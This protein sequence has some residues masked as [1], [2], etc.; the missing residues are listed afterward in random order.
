MRRGHRWTTVA[1]LA[2]VTLVPI[3]FVGAGPASATGDPSLDHL[4]VGDPVPGWTPLPSTTLQLLVTYE[5]KVLG[6]LTNQPVTAAVQ[7]WKDPSGPGTLLVAVIRFPE[8]VPL[9]DRNAREGAISACATG[10]ATAP[11]SV[12]P[13][14]SVPHS[15]E[16]QCSGT[17]ATGAALALTSI[18]WVNGDLFVLVDG[19]GPSLP[20]DRVESYATRQNAS[21]SGGS[22]IVPAGSSTTAIVASLVGALAVAGAVAAVLLVRA[23]RARPAAT[24]AAAS[25][26]AAPTP[27]S[28]PP[29]WYPWAGNPWDLG[30]WD[31]GRWTARKRWDGA[32]WADWA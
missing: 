20:R 7:G 5:E 23:R 19:G 22:A 13:L 4:I 15:A 1:A 14:P 32:S 18:A 11:T 28:A 26:P 31:G 30:Y 10:T 3:S 29:G 12:A 27:R 9:P 6:D 21:I 8:V 17:S 2:L 25:P 16:A 24:F